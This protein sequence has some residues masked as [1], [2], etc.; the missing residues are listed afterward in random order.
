MREQI[1]RRKAIDAEQKA[2]GSLEAELCTV[3]PDIAAAERIAEAASALTGRAKLPDGRAAAG[4]SASSCRARGR[5]DD[6]A[7]ARGIT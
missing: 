1:E 3:R 6:G 7:E 2:L 4:R 5:R